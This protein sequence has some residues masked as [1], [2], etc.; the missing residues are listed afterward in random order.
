MKYRPTNSKKWVNHRRNKRLIQEYGL[1]EAR[2]LGFLDTDKNG[3]KI[4]K[5]KRTE[6]EQ[7]EWKKEK[8]KKKQ[9]K[10]K[11]PKYNIGELYEENLQGFLDSGG[12]LKECP[13][14]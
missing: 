4:K 12:D 2:K 6:T 9:K 3:K 11:E 13:F 8:Y 14:D 7:K 5:K 10:V 1:E